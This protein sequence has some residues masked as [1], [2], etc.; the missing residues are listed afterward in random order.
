MILLTIAVNTLLIQK[1]TYR[2]DPK[3]DFSTQGGS[4]FLQLVRTLMDA[5][6][7]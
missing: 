2:F 1:I 6:S 3:L 7:M 4:L 5:F